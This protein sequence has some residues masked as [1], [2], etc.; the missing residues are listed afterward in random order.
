MSAVASLPPAAAVAP[1]PVVQAHQPPPPAAAPAMPPA[2]PNWGQRL[3]TYLSGQGAGRV[4]N[5]AGVLGSRGTPT[6]MRGRFAKFGSMFDEETGA[7]AALMTT[8]QA[9]D[10]FGTGRMAEDSR[11]NA[12]TD[13]AAYEQ[14]ERARRGLPRRGALP[15]AAA[16]AAPAAPVADA[17]ENFQAVGD[18]TPADPK[19]V[20]AV[21]A[22]QQAAR[23]SMRAPMRF[24]SN[25]GVGAST[26]D[27]SKPVMP[28]TTID[29][30]KINM[31]SRPQEGFT[32]RRPMPIKPLADPT[33]IRFS[34]VA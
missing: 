21:Q 5:A 29:P 10:A 31:G 28:K 3:A 4:G 8:K 16:P 20:A 6:S 19:A 32:T 14:A 23:M 17:P 12:K 33:N 30:T 15:V 25:S 22:S 34:R 2:R 1:P 24:T 9:A 13:A 7:K 27:G 26:F 11:Q 18:N